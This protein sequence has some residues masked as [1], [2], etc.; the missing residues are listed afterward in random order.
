MSRHDS[1]QIWRRSQR[2]DTNACVEVAR[3]T[4]GVALRDSSLRDGPTL[5]FSKENWAGFVAEMRADRWR[6]RSTVP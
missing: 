1:T 4:T 2:C 3:L 6:A 5:T